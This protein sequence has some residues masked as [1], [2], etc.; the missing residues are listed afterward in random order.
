M[1]IYRFLGAD[2][3]RDAVQIAIMRGLLDTATI[4]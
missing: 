2:G 4:S 1:A 3:R